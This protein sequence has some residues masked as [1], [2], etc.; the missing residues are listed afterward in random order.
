[1][2][3]LSSLLQKQKRKSAKIAIAH[4]PIKNYTKKFISEVCGFCV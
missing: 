2:K 4:H 3:K 1:M